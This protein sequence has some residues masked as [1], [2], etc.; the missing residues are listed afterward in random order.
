MKFWNAPKILKTG[1]GPNLIMQFKNMISYQTM[2]KTADKELNT[3]FEDKS[4]QARTH[5]HT[6]SES[7]T[8]V[9]LASGIIDSCQI[10]IIRHTLKF[11]YS[12]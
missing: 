6:F 11:Q 7:F 4:L 5:T 10:D 8:L 12:I 2:V 9:S 3:P 1:T